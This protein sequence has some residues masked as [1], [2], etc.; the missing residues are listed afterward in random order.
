MRPIDRRRFVVWAG[1]LLTPLQARAQSRPASRRIAILTTASA[2]TFA[3]NINAFKTG[4]KESGFVEGRDVEIESYYA[5][6][7]EEAL[8]PLAAKI[9]AWAPAVIVAPGTVVVE[10]ARK[11][12]PNVPVVTLVGDIVGTGLAAVLSKPGSG[13]TGVSFQAASLDPKRLELLAALIPKGSAVLNLTDSSAR[14]G[15][16]VALG[17]A[18]RKLGLVSHAI[19]ARTPEEIDIAFDTARKLGVRGINVLTSPF[20]H[21][22]RARI[23]KLAASAKLPAIYQWPETAEQGGLLGY[24]PRLTEIYRQLGGYASRIL[25]GA[26]VTELPVEQPK[27]YELVINRRNARAIGIAIPQSLLLQA[28]RVID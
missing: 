22:H 21:V 28:D 9:A 1:A 10:A 18:G 23:M 4:L 8:A 24:G 15:S 11:A 25:K 27:K 20:L 16:H 5:D 6:G 12:A 14:A 26:S 13:I 3:A 17:D 7:R 2:A 19:E